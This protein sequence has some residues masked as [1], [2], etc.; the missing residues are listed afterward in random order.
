LEI[1][2]AKNGCRPNIDVCSNIEPCAYL[3]FKKAFEKLRERKDY[4]F[5]HLKTNEKTPGKSEPYFLSLDDTERIEYF[6]EEYGKYGLRLLDEHLV[7][8]KDIKADEYWNYDKFKEHCE[9]SDIE[10][11]D[12][13]MYLQASFIE[14]TNDG[15]TEG[16]DAWL[17]QH[18][19]SEF[20]EEIYE[21][22]E[23]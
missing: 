15:D 21:G 17:Y 20:K 8:G 4:R 11:V 9:E 5:N 19:P 18:I 1:D 10:I 7:S 2:A 13:D 12:T 6:K 23:H 22:G 3:K 14:W 16:D